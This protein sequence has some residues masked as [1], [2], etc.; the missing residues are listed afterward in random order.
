LTE[1]GYLVNKFITF[2]LYSLLT[3]HLLQKLDPAVMHVGCIKA[4]TL[5]A[6]LGR[7]EAKNCINGLEQYSYSYEEAG[8]QAAVMKKTYVQAQEGCPQFKYM[9]QF[10]S[11]P[12][13]DTTAMAVDEQ[14]TK[15]DS[16]SSTS[17]ASVSFSIPSLRAEFMC[18]TS[19]TT[20]PRR[21][22]NHSL[23]AVQPNSSSESATFFGSFRMDM[24]D[25]ICKEY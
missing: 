2:H 12:S 16:S 17:N 9:A 22:T 23:R 6:R 19:P 3:C 24:A 7:P 8:D 10:I 11:G 1:H 15:S 25:C 5:L 14:D 13:P 18:V 21:R 4:G 20:S